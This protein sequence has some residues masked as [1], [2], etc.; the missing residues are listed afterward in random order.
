MKTARFV[1]LLAFM[2]AAGCSSASEDGTGADP[3]AAGG[4]AGQAA[5]G[6]KASGGAA[7]GTAAR[8]GGSTGTGGATTATD[9]GAGSGGKPAGTG[10]STGSGGATGTGGTTVAAGPCDALPAAGTWEKI[11]PDGISTA[12]ALMV[13]PFDSSTVWLGTWQQMGETGKDGLFKSTDCG[14]SW[15]HVSTGILGSDV[16][17]SALWSMAIDPITRG[18]MYVVGAYGVMGLLKSTNGGVDW[19]QT[20]PAGGNVSQVVGGNGQWPPWIGSVSMDANDPLHLVLGTHDNCTGAYAPACGAES[21]DGGATWSVFTTPFLKGWA[22]QTGPY[23]IDAHSWLYAAAVDGLW[24]TND[25]G[26][27]WKDVTPAGVTGAAGGEFTTHPLGPRAD[28]SYF[29]PSYNKSGLI[30]S[31]DRG[32]SW[33]VI[34]GTPPANYYL[35][36]TFGDGK[37]YLGDY[38]NLTYTVASESAPTV[39][40]TLAPPPGLPLPQSEAGVFQGA[41][42]L[43]YDP[44]HHILYSNNFKAGVWRQVR[45]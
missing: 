2:V 32:A 38:L 27:T 45:Q 22:E 36:F 1:A 17:R 28:G 24:L 19:T 18:T 12:L 15:A 35:G 23:V 5:G 16:D 7:G 8:T 4:G 13:D 9:G 41:M 40:S 42:Y 34:A 44:A 37:I 11:T 43:D 3:G 29:L 25:R 33:S 21:T 30:R 14:A 20:M 39:W 6:N 26:A 10:G 31:T